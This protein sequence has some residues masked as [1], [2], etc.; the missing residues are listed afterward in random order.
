[1]TVSPPRHTPEALEEFADPNRVS[2]RF[3]HPAR[4]PFVQ[5]AGVDAEGAAPFA[6][7]L[8]GINASVLA[9]YESAFAADVER[10]AALIDARF[11]SSLPFAAG[12]RILALGDSITDDSLSWAF[13]LQAYLDRHRP[14]DGI[15]VINA[16]ITGNTTQEALAR[17]DRIAA[18]RPTWVIQMLGTNDA[19][20]H[21]RIGA[22]MQSIDETRRN[23]RLL[24]ELIAT[25]TDA[26]YVCLTPPPV[27]ESDADAWAPF[28]D[29]RITWREADV[30]E[31]ADAVRAHPGHVVD[32]HTSLRDAP[33][34][35]LLPDGVHPTLVGQRLIVETVLKALAAPPR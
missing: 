9:A 21:G 22:R 35:W 25:E 18:E 2:A 27:V 4:Q 16:G 32:V 1:M 17:I 3:V 12:D 15:R 13:H 19:R 33:V 14:A 24:A 20:R 30:A 34:G 28:R 5:R 26:E 7:A 8:A 11:A 23:L 29:E 6:A 10:S 31:I